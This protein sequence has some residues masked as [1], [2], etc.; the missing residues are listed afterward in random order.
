MAPLARELK[1]GLCL[2]PEAAWLRVLANSI[3]PEPYCLMRAYSA[4]DGSC[5][6]QEIQNLIIERTGALQ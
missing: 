6:W 5:L 4:A 1:P 2:P 3:L